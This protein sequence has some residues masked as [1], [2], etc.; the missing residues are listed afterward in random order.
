MILIDTTPLVALCDERDPYHARARRDFDKLRGN[1]FVTSTAVL[2]EA[3]YHL[4][5]GFGRRRLADA[6]ADLQILPLAEESEAAV[7]TELFEWLIRY[8]EHSPDM[9]DGVAAVLSGRHRRMK[10]WTYDSEF[11]KIWR[12]T[13]GTRIPLVVGTSGS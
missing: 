5:S 7:W 9:A 13:D 11:Q 12:R 6:L 10:V 8:A 4:S 2:G 1:S 3:C